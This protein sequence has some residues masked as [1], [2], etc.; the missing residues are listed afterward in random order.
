MLELGS[1]RVISAFIKADVAA[2]SSPE[3]SQ[4]K[5]KREQIFEEL[6]QMVGYV[7]RLEFQ[8]KQKIMMPLRMF[9]LLQQSKE[10]Q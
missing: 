4:G 10:A 3:D 7:K 6:S 8:I 5:K 1:S 2:A 9:Q